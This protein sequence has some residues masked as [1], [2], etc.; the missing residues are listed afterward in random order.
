MQFKQSAVIEFFTV[1]K[2]P[3]IN[4]HCHMQAVCGDKCVDLSTIRHWVWQYKQEELGETS[5]F[6]KAR[7]MGSVT[8]NRQA[9]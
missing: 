6:D 3:P 8:G 1:E 9:S 2:I 5:L 7:L 4:I